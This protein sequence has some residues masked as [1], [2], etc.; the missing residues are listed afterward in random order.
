MRLNYILQDLC[1]DTPLDHIWSAQIFAFAIFDSFLAIADE[2]KFMGVINENVVE[3]TDDQKYQASYKVKEEPKEKNSTK[4]IC[5]TER[6]CTEVVP[7]DFS[8]DLD[9]LE[10]KVL[11]MMEIN[12][13]RLPSNNN[14][15][16]HGC[17]ERRDSFKQHQRSH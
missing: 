9:E 15:R 10:A 17:V 6:V 7:K 2:L 13:T 11:S 12:E 14:R 16:A 5:P 4:T 3:N 1:R 8:S